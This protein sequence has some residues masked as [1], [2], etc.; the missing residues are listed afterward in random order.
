[1][2]EGFY[3]LRERPFNLTPD[4]RYL[5]QS[6]KHKDAFAHL[7]YG[8]RHHNGFVMLTGEIGT[9]KTTILRALLQQV[10]TDTN[11][12]FV[13]NP[14]LSPIELLRKI[15]EDF[16]IPTRGETVKD[17]VDELNAYLLANNRAGNS[18]VLVIDEAQNLAPIVLEH[19]RLLSNLETETQKLLQI[20]LVGQPEL[21]EHLELPELRQLNQR[22][23]ARYHLRPLD[24]EETVQYI[25]FRLGV[26]G[27]LRKV[28]FTKGALRAVYR[29]SGGVPR[30]IN[31]I[32]DRAL[33]IGY[34]R[35]TRT[36]SGDIIE[37][38]AR[39][40]R[41]ERVRAPR[42]RTATRLGP[43][44]V[45]VLAALVV[46]IACSWFYEYGALRFNQLSLALTP[47]RSLSMDSLAAPTPSVSYLDMAAHA[48]TAAGWTEARLTPTT[49]PV[50][51][52]PIDEIDAPAALEGGA[53]ELL[54]RWNMALLS[55][56]PKDATPEA[57]GAFAQSNG[58]VLAPMTPTLEQLAAIDLPAFVRLTV[59]QGVVTAALVEI[60][61]ERVQLVGAA[62]KSLEVS[63]S[64]FSARYLRQAFYLLQDASPQAALLK[65]GA[66][67][68]AVMAL[69]RRL[70]A[71]GLFDK[72]VTGTYDAATR[73]AV[74]ALQR[75]AGL[76]DDGIYGRNSRLIL[77]AWA[78]TVP[79]PSLAK[80][81][82]APLAG[83][84]DDLER[85]AAKA[86]DKGPQ[87]EEIVPAGAV[88]SEGTAP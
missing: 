83:L 42:S 86:K 36:I 32:C 39:E 63:R 18:C 82:R 15:N 64:D 70:K 14:C 49:A 73:A 21:S 57:L 19:I 76:E 68:P 9:G 35:E 55:E 61:D 47:M 72:E 85:V 77:E 17:L 2:Y 29:N 79:T 48:Q 40:V 38:A 62:G 16:G 53:I 58:L 34:T 59:G 46:A 11:I 5:F 27:G 80:G 8:I 26:A 20:F 12:A 30:L 52:N 25:A 84:L 43:T 66:S 71:A 44:P 56:C 75:K 60:D 54:R 31:S 3:G 41:G 69:Q 13:F 10:D 74:E 88:A 37:K 28:N 67:G 22:I 23:T 6:D 1:M 4:P 65:P 81:Q 51:K 24:R 50:P 45:M 87:K 78:P 33:L 7:L